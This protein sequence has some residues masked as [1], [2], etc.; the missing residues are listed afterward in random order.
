M[1]YY[2]SVLVYANAMHQMLEVDGLNMTSV[3]MSCK[4]I[5]AQPWQY[6]ELVYEYLTQVGTCLLLEP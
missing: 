1:A 6:G 5:P 3:S 4:Q 2:D